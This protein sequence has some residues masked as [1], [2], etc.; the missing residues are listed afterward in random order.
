MYISVRTTITFQMPE[1]EHLLKKFVA[2]NNTEDW[3]KAVTT[4]GVTFSQA[5]LYGI[6]TGEKT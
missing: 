6:G 3:N 4:K 2:E 5:K 1:E